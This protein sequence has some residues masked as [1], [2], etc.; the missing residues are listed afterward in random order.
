MLYN[1][2]NQLYKVYKG[3]ESSSNILAAYTYN[4]NGNITN[5][6]N[7][8]ETEILYEYESAKSPNLLTKVTNR[9]YNKAVQ[10]SFTYSYYQNISGVTEQI[11]IS[12]V[13]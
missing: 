3:S 10:S 4:S 7:A 1:D 11:I 2:L 8:N 13:S 12:T 9:K 6:Q 5:I